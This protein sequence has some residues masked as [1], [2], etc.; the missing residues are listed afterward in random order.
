MRLAI[1][2]VWGRKQLK[3]TCLN[4][5]WGAAWTLWGVHPTGG[6]H[7]FNIVILHEHEHERWRIVKCI[8][9]FCTM[10]AVRT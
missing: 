6:C 3:F 8:L 7:Q 9:L 4:N 10:S 2:T 1:T 5:R